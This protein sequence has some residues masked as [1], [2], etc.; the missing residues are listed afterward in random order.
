MSIYH[1]FNYTVFFMIR[2]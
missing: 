2:F 1:H